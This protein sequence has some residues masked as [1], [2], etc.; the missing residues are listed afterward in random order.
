MDTVTKLDAGA[1]ILQINVM[2]M[3]LTKI[4]DGK[5][6]VITIYMSFLMVLLQVI[7][8]NIIVGILLIKQVV[9]MQLI[10]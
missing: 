9:Q 4:A 5:H 6:T 1:T 7:V 8:M 2:R 10:H 3:P